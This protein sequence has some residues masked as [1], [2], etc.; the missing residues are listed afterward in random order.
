ML[1]AEHSLLQMQLLFHFL[2]AYRLLKVVLCW[3]LRVMLDLQLVTS[4]L[5]LVLPPWDLLEVLL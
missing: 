2:L 5:I 1:C 4:S 3:L